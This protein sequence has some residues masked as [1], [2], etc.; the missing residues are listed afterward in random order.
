MRL[1]LRLALA[2]ADSGFVLE[3]ADD[4]SITMPRRVLFVERVRASPSAGSLI[5]GGVR[6]QFMR[7]LCERA[8]LNRRRQCRRLHP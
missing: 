5:P 7:M 6:H 8:L 3:R 4:G 1:L 2:A